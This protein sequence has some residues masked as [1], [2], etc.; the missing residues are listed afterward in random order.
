MKVIDKLELFNT[1]WYDLQ[2]GVDLYSV[3]VPSNGNS[4]TIRVYNFKGSIESEIKNKV[5]RQ[6]IITFIK[7]YIT[8]ERLIR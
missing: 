2:I 5:L 8:M 7:N 1:T 3:Q 6:E 4:G